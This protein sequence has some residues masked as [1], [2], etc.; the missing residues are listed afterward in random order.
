MARAFGGAWIKA[1]ALP[2]PDSSGPVLRD[3]EEELLAAGEMEAAV[4]RSWVAGGAEDPGP[5]ALL[6]VVHYDELSPI[7][8]TVIPK[9]QC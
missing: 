7:C 6:A 3:V 2:A 8:N 1:A 9:G 4:L 5:Y